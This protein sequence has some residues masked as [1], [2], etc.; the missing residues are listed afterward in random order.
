V[1]YFSTAR[2]I[3]TDSIQI[4][5]IHRK[6]IIEHKEALKTKSERRG[7]WHTPWAGGVGVLGDGA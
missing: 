7:V 1:T 4:E 2:V 3:A 6:E 5:S